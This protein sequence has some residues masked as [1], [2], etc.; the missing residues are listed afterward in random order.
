MSRSSSYPFYLRIVLTMSV[1]S[2]FIFIFYLYYYLFRYL[3]ILL[4]CFNCRLLR[5]YSVIHSIYCYAVSQAYVNCQ[6]VA[7]ICN[8]DFTFVA[9]FNYSWL[10]RWS[11]KS[12]CIFCCYKVAWVVYVSCACVWGSIIKLR[13]TWISLMDLTES[14]L[15]YNKSRE[16]ISD[17]PCFY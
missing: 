11:E 17:K 3:E 8:N 5:N 4:F 13:C 7:L 10:F 12:F 14:G 6:G 9:S 2:S 16:A 1:F 15:T